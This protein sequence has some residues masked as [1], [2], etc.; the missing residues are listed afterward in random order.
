MKSFVHIHSSF[1]LGKKVVFVDLST[2]VKNL[3]I[4]L[5]SFSEFYNRTHW[6]PGFRPIPLQFTFS[7]TDS[8][9]F[10]LNKVIF[11]GVKPSIEI[12]TYSKYIYQVLSKTK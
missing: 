6:G 2:S 9:S 4:F 8:P 7:F 12:I 1:P 11:S 3:S 10:Y 5:E